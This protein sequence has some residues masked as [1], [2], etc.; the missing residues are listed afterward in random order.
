MINQDKIDKNSADW[1]EL[2]NAAVRFIG[3]EKKCP[4]RAIYRLW[5]FGFDLNADRMIMLEVANTVAE[6]IG[7]KDLDEWFE[8]WFVPEILEPKAK[9][10]GRSDVELETFRDAVREMVRVRRGKR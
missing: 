10:A 2:E 6:T 7:F 1:E 8:R 5:K 3:E 9:A 4:P